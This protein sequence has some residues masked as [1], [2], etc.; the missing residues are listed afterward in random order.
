MNISTAAGLIGQTAGAPTLAHANCIVGKELALVG[1]GN[2]PSSVK[3]MVA[4]DT[5]ANPMVRIV[6]IP[7][8]YR[9]IFQPVRASAYN[10]IVIVEFL[11]AVIQQA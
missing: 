8:Q 4:I 6:E 1:V 2:T 5:V 3:T 11:E 9:Q 10:G 7:V